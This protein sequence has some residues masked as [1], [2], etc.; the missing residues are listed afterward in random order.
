MTIERFLPEDFLSMSETFGRDFSLVQ[1]AGG[2]TS[3][4]IGKV[5]HIKASGTT[6]SNSNTKKIFVPVD[7]SHDALTEKF[8]QING[9]K[10]SIETSLHLLLQHKVV[11]HVHAVS[12]IALAVLRRAETIFAEVLEGLSWVYVPYCKPGLS[13]AK[14]VKTAIGI[15]GKNP[16]IIILG[17][18]GLVVGGES[19]HAV[20]ALVKDV[21]RRVQTRTRAVHNLSTSAS[22]LEIHRP[23][24]FVPVQI[25]AAH[26]TAYDAHA[27]SVAVGGTLY[28][29]HVVF[30]K[31]GAIKIESG[32]SVPADRAS[33]LVLVSG[34]G[35]F[36]PAG[37][38][39]A[40]HDM[41]GAIGLVSGLIPEGFAV[42]YL[43]RQDED[44]L[45]DWDAERYRQTLALTRE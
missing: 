7:L 26:Q 38:P 23:N 9:L 45:L 4:K 32:E 6:L 29:D 28:P 16:D 25:Q 41:A 42:N 15:N 31:R 33:D 40:A 36:I 19:P 39:S 44:E 1:G 11:A 27:L 2:N 21:I 37:A 24:G 35:A 22:D 34:V 14:N 3:I 12:V 13:L 8:P 5:M 20:E 10:P 43:S 17:N 18:H 30:L